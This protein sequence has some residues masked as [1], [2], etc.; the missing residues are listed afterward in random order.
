M[1]FVTGG[2]GLVG[3]HILLKLSQQGKNF[4]ALKR[5]QSS[6]KVCEKVFKYYNA[7]ELYQKINW[8]EGDILD[9]GSLEETIQGCNMVLHCAAIVSFSPYDIDLMRKVNIEGTANVMNVALDAGVKRVGYVSSIAALGTNQNDTIINESCEF[10][11]TK[12]VSNYSV[13]KYLAEQEVWRASAEGMEVVIINPSVI[14]GPGDWQKG[15]S[16]IFEKIYGGLKFY[17]TGSTGYVDVIDVAEILVQLLFS[18]VK[19]EK[20]IVNGINLNYQDCFAKIAEVMRKPKAT[21]KV[22]PLLKEF[23]WRIESVKSF[24]TG[25]KPLITRETAN[26]A[27]SNKKYDSSKIKVFLSYN[28][29]DFDDTINKYVN[30]FLADQ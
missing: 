14:L 16:Q 18:S 20:Y 12:D 15:S 17:T 7:I 22:T 10:K 19:N 8:V 26:S 25:K 21:I 24:F 11:F 4:R 30:W 3:S 13:T 1:I 2:T 27:M 5:G 6:L 23:A 9:L 28:F 29:I